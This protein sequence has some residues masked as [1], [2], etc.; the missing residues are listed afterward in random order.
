MVDPEVLDHVQLPTCSKS[1]KPSEN[2]LFFRRY[3]KEIDHLERSCV[4]CSH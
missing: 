1:M 2:E 3:D 4:M